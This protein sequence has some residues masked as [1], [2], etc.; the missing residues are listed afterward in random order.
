VA[1]QHP[2]DNDAEDGVDDRRE[3]RG[4]EAHSK[5]GKSPR[6]GDD[7]PKAAKAQRGRLEHKS[8][9]RDEDDQAQIRQSETE[10]QPE[11]GE[12]ARFLQRKA[13]GAGHGVFLKGWSWASWSIWADRSGRR[14]R[15]RRNAWAALWPIRR[16][17]DRLSTRASHRGSARD[18]S[19][20]PT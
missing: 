1:D 14:C 16:T 18:P 19:D 11:S 17:A 10:R 9:K 12:G 6:S 15:P 8:G 4:E 7:V 13:A 5:C 2:G 20:R 3:E